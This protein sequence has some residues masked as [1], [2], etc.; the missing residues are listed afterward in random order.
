[1]SRFLDHFF[2]HSFFFF[3]SEN[4]DGNAVLPSDNENGEEE[5]HLAIPAMKKTK[6]LN[7]KSKAPPLNAL[8]PVTMDTLHGKYA[9]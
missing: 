1:M 2:S 4:A 5:E 7:G 9:R 3:F 8:G 6:K